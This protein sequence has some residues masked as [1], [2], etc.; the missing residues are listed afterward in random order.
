LRANE[1]ELQWLEDSCGALVQ[2][3]VLY[4]KMLVC[5][6]FQIAFGL[7]QLGVL[8]FKAC[9]AIKQQPVKPSQPVVVFLTPTSRT[10]IPFVRPQPK[11]LPYITVQALPPQ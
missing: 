9:R 8:A 1:P 4:L 3:T 11:K 6:L 10:A 5:G 2:Y 7:L